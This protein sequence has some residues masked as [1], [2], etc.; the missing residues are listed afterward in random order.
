MIKPVKKPIEIFPNKL[1]NLSNLPGIEKYKI[2]EIMVP[3][4]V[5]VIQK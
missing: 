4:K 3:I 2:K 5:N 1:Y